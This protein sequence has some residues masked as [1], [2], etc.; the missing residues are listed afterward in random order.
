MILFGVILKDRKET[1]LFV[2]SLVNPGPDYVIDPDDRAYLMVLEKG[3]YLS[4][5]PEKLDSVYRE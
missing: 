2:E 1:S 5:P 4:L 3:E